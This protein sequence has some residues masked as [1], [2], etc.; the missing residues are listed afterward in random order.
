MK[1]AFIISIK[2]RDT[3]TGTTAADPPLLNSACRS[4]RPRRTS[5]LARM[6]H[7]Q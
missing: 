3:S 5:C 1:Q 2:I 4:A 7:A 6:E